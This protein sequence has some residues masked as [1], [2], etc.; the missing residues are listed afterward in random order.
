MVI[1]QISNASLYYEL[2][3]GIETG[4]RYLETTDFSSVE[5]GK[6]DI[7]NGCHVIVQNY[8]TKPREEKRWEAHQKYIDIQFIADGAELMGYADIRTLRVIEK[9]NESKDVTW[10]EGAG[11][12]FTI[13]AGVFVILFPD[14]AHMPGVEIAAPDN[15]RKV[16]V[17]VP[18]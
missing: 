8:L 15:V 9:Y 2:G 14:D 4:L 5:P 11:S 10:L 6:Y 1:D 16:V 7:D 12:F 3:P 13:R 18:V 17:K